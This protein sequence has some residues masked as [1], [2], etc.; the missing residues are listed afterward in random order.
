MR[1]GGTDKMGNAV[2]AKLNSL[3]M[4]SVL[5]LFAVASC[6]D[7]EVIL[8][9]ERFGTREALEASIPVEGQPAPEAVVDASA[10][11]DVP[12]TLPA[13]SANADWTHRAGNAR[14]LM[15]HG[16]LSANPVRVW[17]AN[18]GK[19]TN[20]RARISAAP[21]V[22]DGRVFTMDA[23]SGVTATSTAGGT[24][25]SA[26]LSA[27]FDRGGQQSGGGLAVAGG[28]LFVAT[29]FG[30]LVALA[31]ASGEVL[32][33]QR[34]D[35]AI[36]GA[37]AAVDGAVFVVG[38]DGTAWGLDAETGKVLWQAAGTASKLGV[39]GT[40]APAVGERAVI[41]PSAG[42]EIM[43][44]TRLGGLKVWGISAAGER[45]G[46][47][48]A[49]TFDVTSDPV[50]AG[51]VTYAGTSAGRTIA[52]SSSSGDRI[53][54]AAEGAMGPVL[55][56]GGSVFLVNDE[57]R[58]VR[59]DAATGA[60][61]WSVDMPYFEKD[62]PKKRKGVFAHY[63]PVLAGGRLVVASSDGLLRF[64]S[65][66]DG[67]LLSTLDIPGGAAAQPA[68]AGGTIYVVGGNGQLH[69]FR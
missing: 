37:P 48:F 5:A 49:A 34:V 29:G 54:S 30:E 14:H 36:S 15:P 38:R 44:V 51:D 42:G 61:T 19:G 62:K 3:A 53:W 20:R 47:A 65:P 66:T 11:V 24:L 2:V 57:A 8:P 22:A 25:W 33:R 7:R 58:L 68:L 13:P 39:I 35:A 56:V 6:G 26:D 12:I 52:I 60:V 17:S 27:T 43:A 63:G 18:I 45:L 69:A 16:A 59:L 21:V 32:W 31:P 64:F 10:T 28:R 1:Q 67:A 50:V 46:R 41:F 23:L 55:P 4:T 40:S 9:G